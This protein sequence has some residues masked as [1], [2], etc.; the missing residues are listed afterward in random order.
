[1]TPIVSGI[2]PS[3]AL[4]LGNYF[5]AMRQHLELA[6]S[7]AECL[8][9]IADYHALTTLRDPALLRTRTYQI[10][11]AY[12]ALGLEL[13]KGVHLVRQSDFPEVHELAWILGCVTNMGTLQRAHSYKDLTAKNLPIPVGTFAYPLLMASDILLHEGEIIPVGRDQHQHVQIAEEVARHF[14]ETFGK[15]KKL[16]KEPT[17]QISP[18]PVVPGLDGHKMSKSRGNTIPLFL[19][20]ADLKKL[21]FGIKTTSTPLGDPLEPGTEFDL[22][23]LFLTSETELQKVETAYASGTMNGKAFGYGHAKQLLISKIEAM[24]GPFRGRYFELLQD[25]QAIERRLR[26]ERDRVAPHAQ[27]V[28]REVR[29]ACGL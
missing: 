17:A 27:R 28:I 3:G 19:P 1:M 14:N 8:F 10:A 2:Q 11:A 6:R 12:L 15:G 24:F 9:F 21:V 13:S 4:H 18:T 7:G 22:L 26:S 20:P 25:P 16:L 29:A 23:K 5:G